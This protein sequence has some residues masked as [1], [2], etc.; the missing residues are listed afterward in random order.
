MLR[1]SVHCERE[2][3]AVQIESYSF[4]ALNANNEAWRYLVPL[5]DMANHNEVPSTNIDL[6]Q[7]RQ[8]WVATALRDIR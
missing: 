6:D 3:S 8:A 4:G 1:G 7:K 5:L 2:C